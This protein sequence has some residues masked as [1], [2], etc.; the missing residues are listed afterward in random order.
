MVQTY[1]HVDNVMFDSHSVVDHF[2]EGW[3]RSGQQRIGYLIGQ[4]QEYSDVPLGIRAVVS[5]IYE[6]PQVI[7]PGILP[8]QNPNRVLNDIHECLNAL[9]STPFFNVYLN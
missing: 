4:Y 1:R 5:A 2:I 7:S 6:P 8:E 9:N 3:R